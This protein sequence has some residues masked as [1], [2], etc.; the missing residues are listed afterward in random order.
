MPKSMPASLFRQRVTFSDVAR[1][2]NPLTPEQTRIVAF[3]VG[4]VIAGVI[5]IIA[6]AGPASL[7]IG[8]VAGGVTVYAVEY[9]WPTRDG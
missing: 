7:A 1:R 8:S 4:F 9:D 3:V 2:G 6:G 5:A